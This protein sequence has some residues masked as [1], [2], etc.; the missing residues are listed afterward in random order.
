MFSLRKSLLEIV[1]QSRIASSRIGFVLMCAHF[2]ASKRF[3]SLKIPE[4]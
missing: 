2:R 4:I 1:P 3:H